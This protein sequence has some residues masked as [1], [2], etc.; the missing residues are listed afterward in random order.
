MTLDKLRNFGV[1]T[2]FLG[3]VGLIYN[4]KRLSLEDLYLILENSELL[5]NYLKI[6]VGVGK[7]EV[8]S[9]IKEFLE[10]NYDNNT[11]GARIVNTLI[12]QYFIK[13]GDLSVEDVEEVTFQKQLQ[14]N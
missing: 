10:K 4:T 14:L 11:I 3:R 6:F 8:V 7:Y 1:K 9:K 13:G 12:N 2:E 5:E